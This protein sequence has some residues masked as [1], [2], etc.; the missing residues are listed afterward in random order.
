M[1]G[2]YFYEFNKPLNQYQ[3]ISNVVEDVDIGIEEVYVDKL[4]SSK[5]TDIKEKLSVESDMDYYDRVHG[6]NYLKT[7]TEG[8]TTYGEYS[9]RNTVIKDDEHIS[10]WDMEDEEE[11]FPYS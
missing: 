11:I 3:Q 5:V 4:K 7:G 8:N 6:T 10:P 1:I 2:D 9:K